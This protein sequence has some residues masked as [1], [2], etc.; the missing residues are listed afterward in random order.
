MDG[1]GKI[2]VH[3]VGDRSTRSRVGRWEIKVFLLL[4]AEFGC[5][6]RCYGWLAGW[7]RGE[8]DKNT[9]IIR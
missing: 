9:T 5:R 8:R 3:G 2:H 1:K 7:E 6:C 4:H